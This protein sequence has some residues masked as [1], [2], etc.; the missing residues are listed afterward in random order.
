MSSF[1]FVF[2]TG[3]DKGKTRIYQQ[4]RI[5]I[6]TADSCDLVLPVTGVKATGELVRLPDH[7]ASVKRSEDGI[8]ILTLKVGD[9]LQFAINGEP[10]AVIAPGETFTLHDGD[11][12]RFGPPGRGTEL[13]FHVLRQDIYGLH[14]VPTTPETAI[15]QDVAGT[16][17]PLTATL[18]VRELATS[19]WAE[20]P[21]RAK[22]YLIGSIGAVV[23]LVGL[24]VY[25]NFYQL[26]TI[27]DTVRLQQDQIEQERREKESAQRRLEDQQRRLDELRQLY[28]ASRSF[29]E[30]TTEKYSGGV[31][32]IV[33]V[34]T[35]TDRETGKPLKYDTVDDANGP[36]VGETG[37]LLASVDGLGPLVEVEFTGTG[38]LVAEN[39]VLTNRHVVQPWRQDETAQIIL[40]QGMRPKVE[41]LLAYFPQFQKPF[42]IKATTNSD[43][44]DLALC[45]IEQDDKAI[46]VLPISQAGVS[47]SMP[48][49]AIVLLGYPTGV[50]GLIER[51]AEP[52]RSNILG[53]GSRSVTD[54]AQ[55]LADRGAIR[56]LTTQGIVGDVTPGRIVHNAATTEG[57]SGGPIFD[58]SERVI[59]V[60]AAILVSAETGQ[61]FTGS[62]FAIPIS[63]AL[64]MVRSWQ[65]KNNE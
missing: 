56:P 28:E 33:G 17:H 7:I 12:V 20:I 22:A 63:A 25:L 40:S 41:Q 31:C 4:D 51:L 45:R 29:A 5:T 53:R 6:G 47:P 64:P 13:L 26:R 21:N 32:L 43:Q 10:I 46:P 35:F 60:N 52:E 23:F 55:T 36:V 54:V 61:S 27:Q 50:E 58:E 57:G 2:L 44:A 42:E 37:E 48:G 9:E 8:P 30:R 59:A 11:A 65:D 49:K 24:V 1:M 14:P 38:F 62:N 19:L 34:Y 3:R 39:A 15:T 18:F 16:V